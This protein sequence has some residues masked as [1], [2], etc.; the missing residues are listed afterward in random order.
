MKTQFF[1]T[2]SEHTHSFSWLGDLLPTFLATVAGALIAFF[3]QY[4]NEKN[5]ERTSK[6][7]L[8]LEAQGSLALQ[9]ELVHSFYKEVEENGREDLPRITQIFQVQAITDKLMFLSSIDPEVCSLLSKSQT[10]YLNLQAYINERNKRL[11]EG[12]IAT[13]EAL[14]VI[15]E[16]A[17]K[18]LITIKEQAKTTIEVNL[19]A[20]KKLERT[21][22]K[23][24]PN[25]W[26][27]F[28]KIGFV[29]PNGIE[30]KD[31]EIS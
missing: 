11:E 26:Y 4:I 3:L 18:L 23:A 8:I 9:Y 7:D 28:K 30:I 16:T 2:A 13:E 19:L 27:H 10:N 14:P 22:I 6:A 24:I 21:A 20:Q 25:R 12:L 15:M 29:D 1:Y 31:I 17:R 5:K